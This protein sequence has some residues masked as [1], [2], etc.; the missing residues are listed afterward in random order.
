MYNAHCAS[1][2]PQVHY[3]TPV[4][5]IANHKQ[6]KLKTAYA[7]QYSGNIYTE[8]KVN[9]AMHLLQS[10]LHLQEHALIQQP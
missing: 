6:D 7:R 10:K 1:T 2:M 3:A 9:S 4:M 8:N 5:I